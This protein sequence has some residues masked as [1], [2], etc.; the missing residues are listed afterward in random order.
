MAVA[1]TTDLAGRERPVREDL[2]GFRELLLTRRSV[3]LYAPRPVSRAVLAELLEL[4]ASA[5]SNFNRQPWQFLVADT[6]AACGE[7][8][9]QLFARLDEVAAADAEGEL[10]AFLDHT[11]RWAEPLR[12]A[13]VI[14][15]AFYKPHPERFDQRVAAHLGTGDV[16]LWSPNLMSLSMA[17]QN[18]LLAAHQRGLGACMH[19]GPVPF[20]R[21]SLNLRYRLPPNLHLA[22]LVSLGHP[23]ERPEPPPHRPLERAVRFLDDDA[24]PGAR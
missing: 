16:A 18:L 20:L 21:L 4:A 1:G 9:D 15:L 10:Y 24:A 11:R 5:P 17:I 14:V 2:D 6:P 22:G 23:A 13:P 8:V 7:I 19:S 3:R 12:T